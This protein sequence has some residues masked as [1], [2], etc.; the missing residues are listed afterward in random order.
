M[1]KN[2]R[3]CSVLT[4]SLHC[5][6]TSTRYNK[7]VNPHVFTTLDYCLVHLSKI[8]DFNSKC[9]SKLNLC[10]CMLTSLYFQVIE[11]TYNVQYSVHF[12]DNDI[13]QIDTSSYRLMDTKSY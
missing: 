8:G 11:S 7:C 12:R 4:Y 5:I 2:F 1:T 13:D 9:V 3:D 6:L 10:P